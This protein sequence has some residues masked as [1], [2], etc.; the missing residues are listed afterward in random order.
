MVAGKQQSPRPQ[1]PVD[2]ILIGRCVVRSSVGGLAWFIGAADGVF[3]SRWYRMAL[4]SEGWKVIGLTHMKS[5]T[6]PTQLGEWVVRESAVVS[7]PAGEPPVA[8][9]PGSKAVAGYLIAQHER[10]EGS[11]MLFAADRSW[12]ALDEIPADSSHQAKTV[13]ETRHPEV[14]GQWHSTTGSQP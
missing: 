13:A 5:S 6:P 8:A 9:T 11:W 4:E 10:E 3:A 14:T 2:G 7:W 1:T 12:S